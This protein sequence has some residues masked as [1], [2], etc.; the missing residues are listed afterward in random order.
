[1]NF[2]AGQ[3]GIDLHLHLYGAVRPRTLFE[4]AHSRNI[5]IPYTTP[6]EL[7]QALLP[8]KPYKLA[9]FL[10]GFYLLLPILAGDKE[11]IARITSECIED[12]ARLGGLCYVELRF[13][14]CFFA[15]PNLNVDAVMQTIVETSKTASQQHGI[16]VRLILSILR[17]LPE[18]AKGVLDLAIKYQKEGVVAI[19]VAGDDSTW[20][21][22]GMPVEIVTVFEKAKELGIH[23]TVHAGENSPAEAVLEAVEKLHAE[24]IGHGYAIVNNPEIYEMVLKKRIHLETCP[25]CSWLTGAVNSV[26]LENHPICQF[27]ADGIDFSINTDAPR[28]V[29]KWIGEELK[30]CQDNLGLTEAELEQCKRNAAKAAFLETEEAKQALLNHLFS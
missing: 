14:P 3:K 7:E 8:T 19:D 21:T 24:R 6:E 4:L 13:S 11:A 23:R 28:M 25:T 18:T 30:F 9:N 5:P 1:M 12:C 10:K 2:G 16:V 15:G 22:V 20:D 26:L 17:H 29:N 27:A